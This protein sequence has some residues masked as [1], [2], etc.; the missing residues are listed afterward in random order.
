[1]DAHLRR[2]F[3]CM[4]SLDLNPIRIRSRCAG[5]FPAG[6]GGRRGAVAAVPV[7]RGVSKRRRRRRES[8]IGSRRRHGRQ[9][10]MTAVDSDGTRPW[11]PAPRARVCLRDDGDPSTPSHLHHFRGVKRVPV[12]IGQTRGCRRPSESSLAVVR[13]VLGSAHRPAGKKE[14]SQVVASGTNRARRPGPSKLLLAFDTKL[15]DRER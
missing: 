5:V 6:G 14:R 3:V 13:I 15:Q 12:F 9:G 4:S 7:P 8:S 10:G 2:T 11:L 1:M